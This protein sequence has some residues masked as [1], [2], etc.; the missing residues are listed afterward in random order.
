MRHASRSMLPQ[1]VVAAV[2]V[3][4]CLQSIALLTLKPWSNRKHGSWDIAA[5]SMTESTI[6]SPHV[7]LVT[8]LVTF[9]A[10]LAVLVRQYMQIGVISFKFYT[11]W[12]FCLL[13]IYFGWVSVLSLQHCRRNAK[14]QRRTVN[15]WEYAAIALFHV[16]L[17]TTWIVDIIT[18][19]VLWPMTKQLAKGAELERLTALMLCFTSY[20]QHGGNAAMLLVEFSLNRIPI[21]GYMLGYVGLWSCAYACWALLWHHLTGL[22][23]YP[24]LD[25]NRPFWGPV[26]YIGLFGMHWLFFGCVMAMKRAK[27]AVLTRDEGPEIEL[28]RKRV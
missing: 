20:V 27:A 22:F 4:G 28:E 8:R 6:G 24:F 11:V 13:T 26:S 7:L 16:V 12:S 3:A 1:A 25:Y 14:P 5:S 2:L 18:W 15:G 9:V 21:E 19:L 17:T 23:L 10:S